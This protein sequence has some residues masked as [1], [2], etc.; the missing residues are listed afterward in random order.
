MLASREMSTSLL[1]GSV[2]NLRFQRF[3]LR[4]MDGLDKGK[5]HICNSAA[6][7]SVG[8]AESNTLVLTDP[9]VSRYHFV[10]NVDSQGVQLRD[11]GSTNGTTLGGFRVGSAYLKAGAVLTVGMT[12][13]RYDELAEQLDEQLSEDEFFGRAL[14]RSVAM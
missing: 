5:E 8:T 6:E 9:T 2:R 13:I 12:R 1:R 3:A 14:G 10:L 7:I 4:V 11:L